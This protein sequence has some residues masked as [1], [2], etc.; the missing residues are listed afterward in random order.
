MADEMDEMNE[1]DELEVSD[2]VVV[3]TDEDDTEVEFEHLDTIEYEGEQYAVLL[4]VETEEEDAA[5]ALILRIE[6]TDDEDSEYDEEYVAVEDEELLDKLF[7][8]FCD[9]HRDEFEFAE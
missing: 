2:D 1:M 8:V 9:R 7:D 5:E 4:P 6:P 3:L